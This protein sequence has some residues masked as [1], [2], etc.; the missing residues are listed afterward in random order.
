MSDDSDSD[1]KDLTS[2]LELSKSGAESPHP[3]AS[4]EEDVDILEESAPEKV[5]EFESLEEYSRRNPISEEQYEN[6]EQQTDTETTEQPAEQNENQFQ[7]LEQET[8]AETGQSLQDEAPESTEN[9]PLET[10]ISD[11]NIPENAPDNAQDDPLAGNAFLG[12]DEQSAEQESVLSTPE[13][14]PQEQELTDFPVDDL[15]AATE[16]ISDPL[17]VNEPN[18]DTVD[19][20]DMNSDQ[21]VDAT[22]ET[23]DESDELLEPPKEQEQTATVSTQK[24]AKKQKPSLNDVKKFAEKVPP[25]KPPVKA[26][27][28]YSLLIEGHIRVTD[29]EKLIDLLEKEN[30]GITKKDIE[31]QLDSGKILIPRIS[32]YAGILIVQNLRDCG[33]TIKLGPADQ[34]FSTKDTKTTEEGLLQ[35]SDQDSHSQMVFLESDHPAEKIPVLTG[36]HFNEYEKIQLIDAISVSTSINSS[37]VEAQKSSEYQQALDALKKEMKY[38]AYRKGA[39]AIIRFSISLTPLNTANMYRL[40][41]L[42]TAIK[43]EK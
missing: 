2:I 12:L 31:H 39:E 32:E 33:A 23:H 3:D 11:D 8:D 41:A 21:Q 15:N 14:A 38:R 26:A 24:K 30:Y 37:I 29:R 27:Y 9:S 42:G 1:K 25:G 5:D 43:N 4:N 7:N 40:H 17:E 22:D 36:D 13:D 16:E 19:P 34:I 6:L 35:A 28:P 10:E 18:D 20:L